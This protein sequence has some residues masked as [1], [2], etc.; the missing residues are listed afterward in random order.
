MKDEC[1][2]MQVSVP[3]VQSD[4][5]LPDDDVGLGGSWTSSLSTRI[6]YVELVDSSQEPQ[7]PSS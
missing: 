4:Q 6:Q 2:M 3:V 1:V 5:V 7:L